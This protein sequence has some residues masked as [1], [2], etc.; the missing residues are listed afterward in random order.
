MNEDRPIFSLEPLKDGICSVEFSTTIS[1][2]QAFFICVAVISSQKPLELSA[3]N[4]DEIKAFQQL[5]VHG[6]GGVQ[7]KVPAIY[8]PNPPLSPVGRV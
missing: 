2:L 8:T 5:D 3:G 6:N 1:S 4:M 7:P